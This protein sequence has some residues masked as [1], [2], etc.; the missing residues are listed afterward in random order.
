MKLFKFLERFFPKIFIGIWLNGGRYHV[1][2]KWLYSSGGS[3]QESLDFDADVEMDKLFDYLNG[4]QKNNIVTYIAVLDTSSIQGAIPT[5]ETKSYLKFPEI[6]KIRDFNDIIFK[7]QD[8]WSLFSLKTE[9]LHIQNKFQASGIDFIFSPFLLPDVVSKRFQLPPSTSMFIITEKDF[10]IVAIFKE[11]K[12]LYGMVAD[13]VDDNDKVISNTIHEVE[14][15]EI[16]NFGEIDTDIEKG[17]KYKE[18]SSSAYFDEDDSDEVE[19]IK[20]DDIL[21]LSIF[22]NISFEEE[23]KDEKE[24]IKLVKEDKEKKREELEKFLD[25]EI[26]EEQPKT[27]GAIEIETTI[28][29]E[30]VYEIVTLSVHQFYHEEIYPSDFIEN[31]Y[32]L[33]NLKVHNSFIQKLEEEFSFETEKIRI[34]IAEL[35]V[36]LIGEELSG[37]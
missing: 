13:E 17:I 35:L 27:D 34:D 15:N 36:S 3:K 25:E 7:P 23:K 1:Y 12:L 21:D 11:G 33:T 26:Q 4:L 32:I 19:E 20:D 5:T 16:F 18:Q 24:Q 14:N 9:M 22:D 31:C 2:T 28:D 30:L 6:R 29:H 37:D 8:G 10:T